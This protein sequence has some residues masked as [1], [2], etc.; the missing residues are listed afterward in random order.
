MKKT[1]KNFARRGMNYLAA[2][3]AANLYSLNDG[4]NDK[5][6]VEEPALCSDSLMLTDFN[7]YL[8]ELRSILVSA[9]PGGAQT[10]ASVGCSGGWYFK[11]INDEYGNVPHHIGVEYFTPKPDVLPDNVEWISQTAGDLS[12][13][14]DGSVDLLISGQNIEHLSLEDLIGFFTHA[15]RV[16]KPGGWIVIDSPNALVS[17]KLCYQ[18][19]EHVAEYS[20]EE[21]RLLLKAAGFNIIN[22]KGLIRALDKN[23]EPE[24][25]FMMDWNVGSQN[26]LRKAVNG[27]SNPDDSFIWWFEAKKANRPDNAAFA[28]MAEKIFQEARENRCNRVNLI[29]GRLAEDKKTVVMDKGKSGQIWASPYIPILKGRKKI[30]MK[31]YSH[32]LPDHELKILNF[33]VMNNSE[34]ILWERAF[35]VSDFRDNLL[36]LDIELEVANAFFGV[37]LVL[38]STGQAEL[39][40]PLDIYV[41]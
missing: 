39:L 26:S 34:G 13:I 4:R 16:L 3:I 10:I 40:I 9:M 37:E 5:L 11:W 2:Q 33:K 17:S 1:I 27:I 22:E 19:P 18:Q 20:T 24:N 14:A 35:S 31:I 41:S 6:N 36:K 23:G 28:E 21:M 32:D 7:H 29:N 8:H 15:W 25:I 38:E 30:K 12:P